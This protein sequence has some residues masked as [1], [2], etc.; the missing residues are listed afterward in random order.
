MADYAYDLYELGQQTHYAIDEPQRDAL[1]REKFMNGLLP[2]LK[3]LTLLANPASFEDAVTIA[4][5]VE[6]V[7][8]KESSS[9]NEGELLTEKKRAKFKTKRDRYRIE[10]LFSIFMQLAILYHI[11]LRPPL[12]KYVY[13][14]VVWSLA[15]GLVIIM[16]Y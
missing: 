10:N 5:R 8:G 15:P 11:T 9:R 6:S 1:I 16:R 4:E 2:H 7:R 12:A 13:V 3:E 14:A